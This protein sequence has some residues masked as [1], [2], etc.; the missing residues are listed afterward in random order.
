MR[1]DAQRQGLGCGE[2]AG[3]RLSLQR[4][5]D[6][7][8]TVAEVDVVSIIRVERQE[9]R[10]FTIIENQ[11]ITDDNLSWEA[12][13]LLVW[14]LSK[15]DGWTVKRDGV[16]GTRRCG[17]DKVDRMLDELEQ[18]GYLTREKVRAPNGTY[19]IESVVRERPSQSGKPAVDSGKSASHSGLTGAVNPPLLKT[20]LVRT[21]E[22]TTMSNGSKPSDDALTVDDVVQA[23]NE[24]CHPV[25][26]HKVT[27][28]SVSRR[29]AVLR[30]IKEHPDIEFWNGVFR[31]IK[32]SPFLLGQNKQGWK[33]TFDWLFENDRN[34]LK[35][36][37]GTYNHA[38]AKN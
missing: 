35:V 37:E 25:G 23:W 12:L 11:A 9:R 14:L 3:Q 10:S 1:Y 21:K 31:A 4:T 27:A 5:L 22:N 13:G 36:F 28:V 30:R 34:V 8:F 17:K 29:N 32:A 15:P 16:V 18:A 19:Y 20:E 33:V 38:A 7:T 24:I 6:P 2:S 26:T